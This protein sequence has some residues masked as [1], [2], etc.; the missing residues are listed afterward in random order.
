M[1]LH[2]GRVGELLGEEHRALI[3]IE[4]RALD[5]DR[6]QALAGGGLLLERVRQDPRVDTLLDE[7]HLADAHLARHRL[8]ILV[9]GALE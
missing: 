5:E 4:Q 9:Y 1:T 7:E 8:V 2:R 3:V 6:D